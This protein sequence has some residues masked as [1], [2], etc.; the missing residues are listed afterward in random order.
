MLSLPFWP[1]LGAGRQLLDGC[2]DPQQVGDLNSRGKQ[3]D[4]TSLCPQMGPDSNRGCAWD[5]SGSPLPRSRQEGSAELE[6]PGPAP[7]REPGLEWRFHPNQT[8]ALD[9]PPGAM[10]TSSGIPGPA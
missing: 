10:A 9:A 4:N 3:K 7:A 1:Q 5:V 2:A 6:G 8:R